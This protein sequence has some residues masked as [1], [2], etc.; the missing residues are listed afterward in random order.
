[1]VKNEWKSASVHSTWDLEGWMETNTL[2]L[3][4]ETSHYSQ[5]TIKKGTEAITPNANHNFLYPSAHWE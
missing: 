1:M 2:K 4:V 3:A 5:S